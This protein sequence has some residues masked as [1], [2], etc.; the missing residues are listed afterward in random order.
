LT[1]VTFGFFLP[2][3]DLSA[4]AY[5]TAEG[6]ARPSDRVREH[7]TNHAQKMSERYDGKELAE[8][9]QFMG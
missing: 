7:L 3:L 8:K 4:A 6:Q 2:T 1:I 9:A 5:Y